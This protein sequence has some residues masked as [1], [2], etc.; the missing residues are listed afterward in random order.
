[1]R[2]MAPP[3][4][5]RVHQGASSPVCRVEPGPDGLRLT[6]V[7]LPAGL[8]ALEAPPIALTV[9]GPYPTESMQPTAGGRILITYGPGMA[10]TVLIPDLAQAFDRRPP[11]M[12]EALGASDANAALLRSD[13][14]WR[15][16][17]LPSIGDRLTDLGTGPVA[18]AADGLR[19]AVADGEVVRELALAD[20]SLLAEHP[21][22]AEALAYAGDAGLLIARGGRVGDGDALAPA[23]R[24]AG[25]SQAAVALGLHADGML[26]LHGP[27]GPGEAWASPVGPPRTIGLSADG[28]WAAIGGEEAVAVVRA[29]DGAIAAR[30]SGACAIALAVGG[31]VAI[32]GPWGLALTGTVQEDR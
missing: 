9:A 1:M 12:A 16:V 27:D 2:R 3:A 32:G 17:V 28:G 29:G 10:R 26:R 25:A 14:G 18:I 6:P 15:A 31:R 30:I 22:P 23:V 4:R 8:T 20:G 5:L 21:G 11:G 7:A 13:D 19:V 24:L